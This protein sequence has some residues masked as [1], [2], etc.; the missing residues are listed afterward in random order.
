[1]WSSSALLG[2]AHVTVN[3][4]PLRVHS[5]MWF[6]SIKIALRIF[7]SLRILSASTTTQ[8]ASL[9]AHSLHIGRY[10]RL[11]NSYRAQASASG[12]LAEFRPLRPNQF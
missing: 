7:P 9:R 4:L 11:F 12:T 5:V 1:M 3:D 10:D 2:L 8:I 6:K